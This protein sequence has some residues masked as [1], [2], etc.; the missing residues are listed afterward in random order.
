MSSAR[1]AW[2]RL[3]MISDDEISESDMGSNGYGSTWI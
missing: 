3:L 1:T 2:R